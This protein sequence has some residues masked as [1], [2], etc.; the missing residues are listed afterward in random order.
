MSDTRRPSRRELRET[1][2]LEALPP[3]APSITTTAELRLRR[4]SRKELREVAE[5][6]R[7]ESEAR[8]NE[9]AQDSSESG[10]STEPETAQATARGEAGESGTEPQAE[11]DAPG[12]PHFEADAGADRAD[13][14]TPG[15]ADETPDERQVSGTDA[16]QTGVD[17][18]ETQRKSVFERFQDT[19]EIAVTPEG[20]KAEED[21]E[22]AGRVS[23]GE[24][25]SLRDRF[26]AMTKS[27][28][29]AGLAGSASA[30]PGAEQAE[31]TDVQRHEADTDLD[32]DEETA[33]TEVEAP[34]R[35]WLNIIIVVLLG[36]L[37]GYLAGS[38]INQKYLSAPM[39]IVETEIVSL[40][41]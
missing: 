31:H 25:A 38:W 10:D 12:S 18:Q 32:Q 9:A 8:Q 22:Q 3:D 40:L 39:P 24:E 4:P 34:R 29:P 28:K 20:E 35:T 27:D 37:V 19:P 11:A 15:G 26:L 13:T 1:G 6:E 21:P 41:L 17:E 5:R 14:E 16:G 23:D 36:A 30:V 33:Q 2:R 7:A